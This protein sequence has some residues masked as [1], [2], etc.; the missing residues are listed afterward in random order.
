VNALRR[1]QRELITHD[2][3]AGAMSSARAGATPRHGDA[4][5]GGVFEE[6]TGLHAER[7]EAVLH[8]LRCSG[9]Q[10]IVDLGCG[11]GLL[12]ARLVKES[13]FRRIIGIDTSMD[14]FSAAERMLAAESGSGR[15]S[16]LH[17]SFTSMDERLAGLDAA[18][19]L[20]TIEHLDPKRLSVAEHALFSRHRPGTVVITTPNQEYNPLYG[21]PHGAFRHP[22]HRFE[23]SR[24]RFA[25][26]SRGVA[27]RHS[28]AVRM[29]GIGAADS[30]LGSPTQMAVFSDK[31]RGSA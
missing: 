3:R 1:A 18:V 12:L 11:A 24:A 27:A 8:V 30:A 29:E 19:M 26:W 5:C 16:L 10:S 31:A 2:G 20:E 13:Q 21:L 7:I 17:M 6:P 25:A 9:A 15:V 28:Y 22:E 4:L 23:W 14:A